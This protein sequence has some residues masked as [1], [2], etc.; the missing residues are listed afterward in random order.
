[1]CVRNI[2]VHID[3]RIKIADFGISRL[4]AD[5]NLTPFKGTIYYMSPEMK[6][7]KF[8]DFKTDIWYVNAYVFL[9][10]TY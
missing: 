8:Y 6:D 1:M 2:L 4:Y 3:N 10:N 9:A 5:S 7:R